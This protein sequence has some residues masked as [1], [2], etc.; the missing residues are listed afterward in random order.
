MRGDKGGATGWHNASVARM[1][2][3]A[4]FLGVAANYR[5]APQ[6]KFPAGAEDV[7][8]VVDWLRTHAAEYG[9]DPARICV[10]GT[11]AG[12]VHVAGY[13]DLRKDTAKAEIAGAVLLSGLYGYTPLD[14]K[15]DAY[16]GS[17]E[18]YAVCASRVYPETDHHPTI[19][20]QPP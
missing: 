1:A 11:S 5:L 14:G 18:N 16:F 6:H 20:R 9:A 19:H 15:D 3:K 10:A 17:Q 7:A 13:L 8:A 2:A 4:G 12:A